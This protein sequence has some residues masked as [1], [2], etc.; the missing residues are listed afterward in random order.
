[1]DIDVAMT[2]QAIVIRARR[3]PGNDAREDRRAEDAVGV[4]ALPDMRTRVATPVCE[5]A[6]CEENDHVSPG[7]TTCFNRRGK[8]HIRD[9]G[10]ARPCPIRLRRLPP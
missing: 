3:W 7:L 9:E 5:F 1:M 10:E 4:T 2:T 6:D 8:R